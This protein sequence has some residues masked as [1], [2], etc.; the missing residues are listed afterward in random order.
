MGIL[1]FITDCFSG[2]RSK[3]VRKIQPNAVDNESPSDSDKENYDFVR[4]ASLSKKKGG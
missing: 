1:K 3:K 4:H 2:C